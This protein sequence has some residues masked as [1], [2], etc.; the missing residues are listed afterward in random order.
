MTEVAPRYALLSVSEKNGIENLAQ[1]L[2]QLGFRI[3]STGGTYQ[4]LKQAGVNAL[5]VSEL[6]EFPEIMD[7]RVKTLQPK[8]HGGILGRIPQ[9]SGLMQEFNIPRIDVVVVNLYPFAA[10]VESGADFSECIENIDIGGPCMIRAAAKN[11]AR[12]TVVV[13]HND[14]S[15]VIDALKNNSNEIPLNFRQQLAA[16]AFAHTAS[17]DHLIQN[18][19]QQQ[20]FLVKDSSDKYTVENKSNDSISDVEKLFPQKFQLELERIQILRYGENPH[21]GGA[22]YR[23]VQT[24]P[25]S[26]ML[27][28]EGV[29]HGT[30]IQGKTLSYNNLVDAQAAVDC[31]EDFELP[32]CVIVKHANPCGVATADTLLAAYQRAFA[33]D[34]TSAFGGIIGFNYEV[35]ADVANDIVQRQFLEVVVAPAFSA[36]AVSVFK[37]KPN[38]R[39]VA[40]PKQHQNTFEL[41]TLNGGFLLQQR[42]CAKIN[43]CTLQIVT[44]H[45]PSEHLMQD[46]LFAWRVAKH[47]KSNAIVY[48]REGATLGIGAG[49]MSR[50]DSARIAIQKAAEFKLPIKN[51]VMASDAFFPFRDTVDWA[52]KQGIS[53]IIQ[54]GGSI[55][56]NEVIQAANEAGIAMV[57]TG[58]RHFKH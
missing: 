29:I 44:S 28:E 33:T 13:D 50:I 47:V 56:D 7:G 39:I 51:A 55:R 36:E 41:K 5:E 2:Q 57:F 6:T 23:C 49:Q 40:Y 53:A 27:A 48:A 35:D 17:Y 22:T 12:V 30:F 19:F 37:S 8:I 24:N 34:P 42:D 31:L 46:L 58:I 38:V 52:A 18:Y 1:Q 16:K 20:N 11:H 54:P 21:Q 26:M 43:D 14:Y 4:K 25:N 15:K 45:Q 10:T 32:S 3:I 9:D